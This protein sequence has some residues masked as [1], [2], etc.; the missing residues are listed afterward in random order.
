MSGNF[1]CTYQIYPSQFQ[2]DL[3]AN[4]DDD[5]LDFDGFYPRPSSVL[6][7]ESTGA[8]RIGLASVYRFVVDTTN[9]LGLE[10]HELDYA[11]V[12][13]LDEKFVAYQ[14]NLPYFAKMDAESLARSAV[15]DK[16]RPYLV[17]AR[18]GMHCA[19]NIRRMQIHRR[20]LVLGFADARFKRSRDICLESARTV[21]RVERRMYE[22]TVAAA[23]KLTRHWAIVHHLLVASLVLAMEYARG[24]AAMRPEI[25]ECCRALERS[26]DS[27]SIAA[28]G[29]TQLQGVL[30]KWAAN[31]QQRGC[32]DGGAAEGVGNDI[33]PAYDV[34]TTTEGSNLATPEASWVGM[35]LATADMPEAD[36]SLGDIFNEMW[37]DSLNFP[38]GLE[39][40]EWD[41]LFQEL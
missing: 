37:F 11:T 9:A 32:G 25:V 39:Q 2:V 18:A 34:R 23:P 14:D 7:D 30:K 12:Q 13:M 28:K 6:T 22:S 38:T 8:L 5:A 17:W 16:Q 40:G 15:L 4:V 10:V 20:W 33:R 36:A 35:P 27:S 19:Y 29:L 3:P 1:T 21:V 24:N 31:G 41:A 26:S